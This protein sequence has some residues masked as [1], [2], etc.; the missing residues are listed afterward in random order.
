MT[1]PRD[2]DIREAFER[3]PEDMRAPFVDAAQRA[4]E[5]EA[6]DPGISVEEFATPEQVYELAVAIFRERFYDPALNEIANMEEFF[7]QEERH[8]IYTEEEFR[9]TEQYPEGV[10]GFVLAQAV[11]QR[12]KREK[13][14]WY[15]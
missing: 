9:L 3:L 4:F 14:Q 5:M 15:E 13:P 1:E 10:P 2:E 7:T 11:I 12:M 6:E 8:K